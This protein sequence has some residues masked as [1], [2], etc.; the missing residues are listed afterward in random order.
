MVS[1]GWVSCDLFYYHLLRGNLYSIGAM[2]IF[3]N[4]F[5]RWLGYI[6]QYLTGSG[7]NLKFANALESLQL[8][9]R[10]TRT[11]ICPTGHTKIAKFIRQIPNVPTY[12][13]VGDT[14]NTWIWSTSSTIYTTL[15]YLPCVIFRCV[16]IFLGALNVN[17]HHRITLEMRYNN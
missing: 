15:Q 8:K 4:K 9:E 12:T 3:N 2:S 16:S 6:Q 14:D 1:L 10:R 5:I 17:S 11:F 13:C 7:C